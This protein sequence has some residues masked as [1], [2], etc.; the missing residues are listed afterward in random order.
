MNLEELRRRLAALI[1]EARQI[2]DNPE[3]ES[4]TLTDEQETRY[5]EIMGEDGEVAEVRAQIERLEAL[6]A[7]EDRLGQSQGRQTRMAPNVNRTGL[8]DSEER[9]LAHFFRTGD[10]GGFDSDM[11]GI[12]GRGAFVDIEWTREL[13]QRVRLGQMERRAATDSTL[14]ITTGDD[15]GDLVPTGFVP[16]IVARKNE[17]ML[18][19][20]LGVRRVPGRGTTVEYPFENADPEP[21]ATTSEQSDAHDQ[22]YERD[23]PRFDKKQFT[24]VK[25][26]KKLELTEEL[27]DDEDASLLEFIANHIGRGIANTHNSLLLTE[28]AANG[29]NLKTFASATAIADGE[30]EDIVFN[31]T[32]SYYLDDVSMPAW[33]SRP[34]TLGKVMQIS[35]DGRI[36]AET[37]AGS[38]ARRSVLG[39]NWFYSNNATAV[40]ASAKSVYFGDWNY[41]GFRE[42]PALRFLRDPY[43]VDGLVILKY[44][45]RTVYGVL[46]A[47]AIGYGSHPT[48]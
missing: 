28:V 10:P 32:L 37:P 47:G 40:Q 26:T 34:T 35:G 38:R 5:Q 29:T 23:A 17:R 36:Y 42:A 13:E 4:R 27:L 2:I 33:V 12:E 15:G 24:L 11:R 31:D 44:S 19:N 20:V 21:F 25:K 9:A 41:V 3:G 8:G 16:Q 18:A 45:F 30:L 43:S 14:N 7:E 1:A 39:Y 22:N 48:G 46:I 6:Q